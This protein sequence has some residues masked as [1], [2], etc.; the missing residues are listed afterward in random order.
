MAFDL[1]SKNNLIL[2]DA[3]QALLREIGLAVAPCP[4]YSE[5]DR[6]LKLEDSLPQFGVKIVGDLGELGR[7]WEH[8]DPA[9]GFIKGDGGPLR[10]L[11]IANNG[12]GASPQGRLEF[13]KIPSRTVKFLAD[14]HTVAITTQTLARIHQL[15][16]EMRQ[17]PKRIFS[18]IYSHPGGVFQL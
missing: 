15:C 13:E 3:V 6:V 5:V 10:L 16:S 4:E 2:I 11:L 8:L 12:A 9:D 14:R 18:R 17:D 7:E 1:Y